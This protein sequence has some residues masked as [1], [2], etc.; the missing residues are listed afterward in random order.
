MGDE[1]SLL[2]WG[3]EVPRSSSKN[4]VEESPDW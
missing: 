1:A 3:L 4:V 2:E